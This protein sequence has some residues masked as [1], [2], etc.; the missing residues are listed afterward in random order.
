MLGKHW[1]NAAESQRK[2]FIEA[3]YQS[4]MQDYGDAMLQFTRDQ[5]KILPFRGDPAANTATVRTEVMRDGQGGAGE[6]QR[7]AARPRAG[8]PGT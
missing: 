4:L 6:L 1:R 5:L 8:R 7:C 3:F 2:R